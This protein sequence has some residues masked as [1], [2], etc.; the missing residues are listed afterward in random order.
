[1]VKDGA[2]ELVSPSELTALLDSDPEDVLEVGD[3][4]ALPERTLRG[5]HR[6]KQGRPRYP[7]AEAL[8]EVAATALDK[9]DVP[10]PDEI[11]PLY[12]RDA[13]VTINPAVMAPGPWAEGT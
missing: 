8:V 1:V 6:V 9:G 2:P 5:L 11:R 13:D 3:T 10:H 4:A 12:L 7:S